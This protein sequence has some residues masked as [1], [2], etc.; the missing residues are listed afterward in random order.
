VWTG[1]GGDT[2]LVPQGV[3]PAVSLTVEGCSL[4]L[5]PPYGT[6]AE[7]ASGILRAAADIASLVPMAEAR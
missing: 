2:W 3:G 1:L 4:E 7:R 5:L 6:L